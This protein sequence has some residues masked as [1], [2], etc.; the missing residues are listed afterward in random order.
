MERV[1]IDSSSKCSIYQWTETYNYLIAFN[2][3]KQFVHE[4]VLI[5]FCYFAIFIHS[6]NFNVDDFG[7]NSIMSIKYSLNFMCKFHVHQSQIDYCFPF[8]LVLIKP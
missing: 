8:H 7:G 1:L 6:S 4:A 3:E 2:L 5:R